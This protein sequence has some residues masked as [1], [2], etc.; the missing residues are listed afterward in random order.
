MLKNILTKKKKKKKEEEEEEEE[1]ETGA[2]KI[3]SHEFKILSDD[4]KD[5]IFKSIEKCFSL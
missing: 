1:E 5:K 3:F 4:S 2:A